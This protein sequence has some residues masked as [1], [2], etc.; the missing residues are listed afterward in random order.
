MSLKVVK[1]EDLETETPEV[2]FE[3][4]FFALSFVEIFTYSIIK[5]NVYNNLENLLRK[6][7]YRRKNE[8]GVFKLFCYLFL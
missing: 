2:T 7:N 6:R 3:I 8:T 1:L 4:G 5:G